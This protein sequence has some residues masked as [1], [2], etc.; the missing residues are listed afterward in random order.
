M[1]RELNTFVEEAATAQNSVLV[2]KAV[3]LNHI[4]SPRMARLIL[5]YWIPW[6]S[7]VCESLQKP[8]TTLCSFYAP[9]Q[10]FQPGT[11]S[12]PSYS[13]MR[14]TS[15]SSIAV[16]STPSS[17]N[18]QAVTH[19]S[20]APSAPVSAAVAA[21]ETKPTL[22]GML[23]IQFVGKK[24]ARNT[25][26]C[27]LRGKVLYYK[28][29]V[30]LGRQNSSTTP[31]TTSPASPGNKDPTQTEF[32][33]I[34]LGGAQIR[35]VEEAEMKGTKFAI[36]VLHPERKIIYKIDYLYLITENE[37]DLE[38]WYFALLTCCVP[39]NGYIDIELNRVLHER[40]KYMWRSHETANWISALWARFHLNIRVSQALRE[41]L[42]NKIALR[43]SEKIE[44]KGYEQYIANLQITDLDFGSR[45]PTIESAMLQPPDST[46]DLIADVWLHY[47]NG[48]AK[49]TLSCEVNFKRIMIVPISCTVSC[50]SLSG[51][52][53][54][55]VPPFPAERLSISF[56]EE[57]IME[58]VIE[59]AIGE[60]ASQVKNLIL[61]KIKEIITER[62]KLAL[63]ERF[64]APH[65]KYFRIPGTTRK[66]PESDKPAAYAVK[67]SLKG[68][69]APVPINNLPT[70][71]PVQ[72]L[73]HSSTSSVTSDDDFA[74]WS[75]APSRA[76]HG[77]ASKQDMIRL[78]LEASASGS[79]PNVLG[80][81]PPS[82]EVVVP[83]S[84]TSLKEESHGVDEPLETTTF[85]EH[86]SPDVHH[87]S[88]SLASTSSGGTGSL[89]DL[90]TIGLSPVPSASSPSKV[91]RR[92]ESSNAGEAPDPTKL[93]TKVKG[94]FR[95]YFPKSDPNAPPANGH[96][97]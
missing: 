10:I 82:P 28:K 37:L 20:P 25:Y 11:P 23:T 74:N 53:Q 26:Q 73:L 47:R 45:P 27:I 24:K 70:N 40:F 49:M 92:K 9:R 7:E 42:I 89:S 62:L 77:S 39:H 15:T 48:D 81:L 35:R 88:S 94:I 29:R 60:K 54:L 34:Q 50:R 14:T 72:G 58:L 51:R 12:K 1:N 55:R 91:H 61:P 93:S 3:R 46:G 30:G 85:V 78:S 76:Q 64:V 44:E 32:K 75:P 66:D 22:E 43:L 84:P 86:M 57:P 36:E 90:E 16:P 21:V 5:F 63:V 59:M 18:L 6:S 68:I 96:P 97:K 71:P 4:L 80:P 52:L 31:S 38:R 69:I 41:K 19:S 83:L 8:D 67:T 17:S 13:T 87:S 56:Y 65:R 33:Q 2:D 79:P 95:S